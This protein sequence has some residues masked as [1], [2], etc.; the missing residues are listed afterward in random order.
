MDLRYRTFRKRKKGPCNICCEIGPLSWDHV[1]PQG[2]IEL[3]PVEIERIAGVFVSSFSLP[4]TEI[5]HDGLCFRTLCSKHNSLLGANF[6]PS[7]N[8][9]AKTIGNFLKSKIFLPP[10][11][12]VKARPTAIARAVL[13]HLL[14]AR[15][16]SKDSFFDE[17]IRELVLDPFIPI[18]KNISIFY[19]IHPY[20]QQIILRDG[21]IPKIRGNYSEF[22]RFGVLKYFPIGFLVTDAEEYEGLNELTYWRDEP[23]STLVEIPIQ[24]NQIHDPYW[25]EAPAPDNCILGGE[26][27]LQS[28]SAYPA[29]H[30]FKEFLSLN[31]EE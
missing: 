10:I 5:S 1:P 31:P 4:K 30:L 9:F 23:Y 18:P 15:L 14:A 28:L 17:L 2:G 16:S 21:L 24:L 29:K 19:W 3:Q 22:Q 12:H 11:L 26:D 6:D 13:G 20:A 27:L 25:P 8:D 7:L